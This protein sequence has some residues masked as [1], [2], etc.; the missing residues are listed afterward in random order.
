MGGT[1]DNPVEL[2]V[3]LPQKLDHSFGELLAA[4]QPEENRKNESPTSA[5]P[6]EEPTEKRFHLVVARQ[7]CVDLLEG[8]GDSLGNDLSDVC[9]DWHVVVL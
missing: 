8:N 9:T 6:D 3:V 5:T 2:W 7:G 4:L 1:H